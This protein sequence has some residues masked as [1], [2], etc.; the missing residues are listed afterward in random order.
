MK[1]WYL[2]HPVSGDEVSTINNNMNKVLDFL[3]VLRS[4]GIH[5]QAPYYADLAAGIDDKD[6][7]VRR[8]S[9][10]AN[11]RC[12]AGG[13]D[14]LILCGHKMSA[15]MREEY[16]TFNGPVL[17]LIG[18]TTDDIQDIDFRS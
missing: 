14:G 15:G 16:E 12:L 9:M 10:D 13:Y 2:A 3:Y 11:L 18:M 4:I 8:A 1:V 6:P 5:A 7:V 17:N